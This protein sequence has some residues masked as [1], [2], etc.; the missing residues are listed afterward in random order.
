MKQGIGSW[1]AVV[2]NQSQLPYSCVDVRE[3]ACQVP[4]VSC[5]QPTARALRHEIGDTAE[6]KLVPRLPEQQSTQQGHHAPAVHGEQDDT[7][8]R[9]SP[10]ASLPST[11]HPAPPL[12]ALVSFAN[13]GVPAPFRKFEEGG[14]IL[15]SVRYCI[16]VSLLPLLQ[17]ATGGMGYTCVSRYTYYCCRYIRAVRD[18]HHTLNTYT[19]HLGP[20]SLWV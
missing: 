12:P 3:F 11:Q 19:P 5:F 14:H 16:R 6:H 20:C 2:S 13:C 18:S 17:L 4:G 9:K 8:R 1:S 10:C 15:P 7:Y